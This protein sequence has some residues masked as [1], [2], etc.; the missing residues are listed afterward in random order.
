MIHLFGVIDTALHQLLCSKMLIAV[1][2]CY[3]GLYHYTVASCRV[4]IEKLYVHNDILC[5]I[6]AIATETTEMLIN[7]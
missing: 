3:I 1:E 5:H 7:G 6:F 2:I 4:A